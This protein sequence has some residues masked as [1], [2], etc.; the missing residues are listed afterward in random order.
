MTQMKDK[1][2]DSLKKQLTGYTEFLCGSEIFIAVGAG[3]SAVI[4][5]FFLL[6]AS[7]RLWD[8]P[9]PLRLI[10]AGAGFLILLYFIY[11][12]GKN[13]IWRKRGIKKIAVKIQSHHKE[14][15][16]RLLGAIE[17]AEHSHDDKN[18]SEEL[19]EAAIRKVAEQASTMDFTKDVDRKRPIQSILVLM[20]LAGLSFL[21]F[22]ILPQAFHNAFARWCKP[23]ASI[24]RYT[25]I[26]LEKF[27]DKINI[28]KGEPYSIVCKLSSESK[29]EPD[30]LTYKLPGVKQGVAYFSNNKAS[31]KLEGLSAPTKMIIRTGDTGDTLNINPVHRPSLVE[32]FAKTKYPEYIGRGIKKAKLKNG[33]LSLL[34]GSIY[35]L[36][37]TISRNITSAESI[38]GNQQIALKTEKNKFFTL[39]SVAVKDQKVMFLW[40]DVLGFT[41]ATSY[42]LKLKIEKDREPFTECV[43]LARFSAIL[44]DEAL[45]ININADDDYGVKDIG[46]SYSYDSKNDKQ[47]QKNGKNI[48]LAEGARDRTELKTE[49]L[50]SADLLGIPEMSLVTFKALSSDYLPGRRSTSSVPYRIYILSY[51]QH[52]KLVQE[53]LE[54]I[55]SDLEDM[56]RREETSLE[57]N[58]KISKMPGKNIKKRETTEKIKEQQAQEQAEKREA[59]KMAEEALTLMKEAL[60]NKKFP[61]KTI[62]EWT[63]FL[64]KM[65]AVSQQEMKNTVNSLKKAQ[66]NSNR[67]KNMAD[68]VENQKKTV[69]KLKKMLKKMDDSLKSLT[70]DNFVNRLKKEAEKEKTITLTLKEMLKDIVGL[71]FDQITGNEREKLLQQIQIQ[72]SVNKNA[73]Y[74]RDDLIAF[75]ARTRIEKYKNVTD[76]MEKIKMVVELQKLEKN[77]AVNYTSR[78]IGQSGKMAEKFTEWSK[79]LSQADNKKA[80][81]DGKGKQQEIDTEFLLGLMRIIQGEQNL[82]EK[83]RYLDK[84]RPAEKQY[85][86]QSL[87]LSGTQGDLHVKLLFLTQKARKCPKA[88]QLLNYAGKVMDEVVAM[89]RKPQTDGSVIAAETEI[90]ELLSGAFQ[91]SSQQAGA[92]SSGM[93]AMLMQMLMQQKGVGAGKTPGQSS[94]GGSTDAQNMKFNDPGFNKE[95][96]NRTTDKT[97][98]TTTA[99]I[100][101]E[102][103]NA[104]EAYFKKRS[105]IQE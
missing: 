60:R 76:D 87:Q 35:T 75:F 86:N 23:V 90:I 80:Q 32:L 9:K 62:A 26:V 31:V 84:N 13:W 42:D 1:I 55:M 70:L 66:K 98:G 18:I 105:K 67:K 56:V 17:L 15:G 52:M 100:P 12:I 74:I 2:P 69:E 92:S 49:F 10:F 54:R 8:T 53:R 48:S 78:S 21:L 61:E 33:T 30:K 20:V 19:R 44:V 16:D 29:W 46:V 43:G 14:L 102:F 22:A 89:L 71:P 40:K 99:E 88:V 93:M 51:E 96:P 58:T 34:Y 11:W 101:E 25:F 28:P 57:K 104:I 6:F 77:I 39:G 47:V 5:S 81:G 94:M 7:D 45:K 24:A 83:T 103:K 64:E 41:P 36:E 91:Q 97:Q 95:D 63:E 65:R 68:A 38:L 73:E 79:M 27:P 85:H 37:G 59:K 4:L 3:I 50:F 72:K 82:R